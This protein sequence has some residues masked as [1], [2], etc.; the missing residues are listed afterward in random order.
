MDFVLR[1]MDEKRLRTWV[2]NNRDRLDTYRDKYR[3]TVLHVAAESSEISA[4]F[5]VW[6]IKDKGVDVNGKSK[7]GKRALHLADSVEKL[8]AL[9]NNDADPTLVDDDGENPLM[10]HARYVRLQHVQLLIGLDHVGE[11]INTQ[12][13]RFSGDSALHLACDGYC[14]EANRKAQVVDLLLQAGASPLLK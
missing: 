5:L 3:E 13:R 1:D 6:L 11:T 7:N 12:L 4:A 8:S 10:A 2:E 14:S 9:L